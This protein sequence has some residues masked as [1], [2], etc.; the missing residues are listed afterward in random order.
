MGRRP[1]GGLSLV[2]ALTSGI[3]NTTA[4]RV[5]CQRQ[6]DDGP[7][8]RSER[9]REKTAGYVGGPY[10]SA[11]PTASTTRSGWNGLTTKSL[12]PSFSAWTTFVS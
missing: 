7:A 4:S 11:L 8:R 6:N 5:R 2:I 12:A 9:G 1:S 3:L 10:A